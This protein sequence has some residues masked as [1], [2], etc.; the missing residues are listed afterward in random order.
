[1]ERVLERPALSLKQRLKGPVYGIL[2][3]D[4]ML[5]LAV[6]L[7]PAILLP[8]FWTFSPFMLTFFAVI[9]YGV[10]FAFILEYVLKLY[11]ADSRKEFVTDP[12]HVLDL[13]I[14]V[15]AFFDFLPF[16]PFS[17]RRIS[18]LLRLT[19]ISRVLVVT[20]RT[21][22]R[23]TPRKRA[24]TEEKISAHVTI[25][26]FD[27]LKPVTHLPGE[28]IGSILKD[29]AVKLVDIQDISSQDLE[30]I[31]AALRIPV[32]QLENKLMKESFPRIDYL[33]GYTTIFIRDVRLLSCD[34]TM[35]KRNI[36]RPAILLV[37]RGERIVSLSKSRNDLFD[38]VMS[39]KLSFEGDPLAVR[40]LYSIFQAK[41]GD[42]EDMA[43]YFEDVMQGL[44][45]VPV[46]S[47][48]P[49]FL[50]ECFYLKKDISRFHNTL[51]HYKQALDILRSEAPALDGFGE[52]HLK[53]FKGPYYEA[54]YLHEIIETIKDNLMSLIELHI[55]T[56]SFDINRVMRVLAQIT[57]LAVIPAIAFGLLGSNLVEAPFPVTAVEMLMIVFTLMLL[58]MFVFYKAGWFK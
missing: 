35:L 57:V 1:M 15:L 32:V 54:E 36:S 8:Y 47:T 52:K 39:G 13:I 49:V 46:K 22:K 58:G 30:A 40:V 51:K 5:L 42:Y 41:L 4:L 48:D 18:P 44:E 3:D 23:V 24:E 28:S 56:V 17:S 11:V 2:S 38:R 10:I 27:D 50:D 53:A 31:S 9:N 45:D 6:L 12:W 16:I 25:K 37:C 33:D 21:A 29:P 26:T 34:L 55:N 20:G 14:I 43:H 7:V 19:R